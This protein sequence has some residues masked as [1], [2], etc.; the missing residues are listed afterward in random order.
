M[1]LRII[2]NHFLAPRF[3]TAEALPRGGLAFEAYQALSEDFVRSQ[4]LKPSW[5]YVERFDELI[6]ALNRGEGDIIIDAMIEGKIAATVVDS[7]TAR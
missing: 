2:R 4:D 3:D 7:D 6:P 5:A 1:I